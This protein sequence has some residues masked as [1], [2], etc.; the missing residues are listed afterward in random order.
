MGASL[1]KE[2]ASKIGSGIAG[3]GLAVA[4][5]GA[6][7]VEP[8]VI[9]LGAIGVAAAALVKLSATSPNGQHYTPTNHPMRRAEDRKDERERVGI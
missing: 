8:A 1:T 4:I 2:Q 9:G 5:L 7:L 6:L 3:L